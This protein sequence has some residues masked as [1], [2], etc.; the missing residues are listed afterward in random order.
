M[1]KIARGEIAPGYPEFM[2]HT[3]DMEP[4]EL[5][6]FDPYGRITTESSDKYFYS[7][8]ALEAYYKEHYGLDELGQQ[9]S[10]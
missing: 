6:V 2:I 5:V 8:T 3:N 9:R 7:Q 4:V 10:C 1:I